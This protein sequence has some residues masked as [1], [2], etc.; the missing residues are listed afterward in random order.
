VISTRPWRRCWSRR[1]WKRTFSASR[2]LYVEDF[3]LEAL[4][5][6]ALDDVEE[7]GIVEAATLQRIQECLPPPPPPVPPER[8]STGGAAA[9]AA[10]AEP[11]VPPAVVALAPEAAAEPAGPKPPKDLCC[12]ITLELFVDP[13]TCVGDGETYERAAIERHICDRQAALEEA[14]QEL[15]D[16]D[17][18]S[19]RAQRTL[20][21]GI[22][23]PMGHGTLASIVLVPARMA[24]R[25]ASEWRTENE[26]P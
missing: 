12:P 20:E 26:V 9:A 15:E 2:A 1:A 6:S 13:V 18:D 19:K 5:A 23:S 10:V 24:K 17:G 25:L 22:L 11:E 7:F 4:R 8:K 16:T 21:H 3:D 14:Q